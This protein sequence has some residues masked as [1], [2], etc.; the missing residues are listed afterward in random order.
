MFFRLPHAQW[1]AQKGSGNK[2]ALQA[3]VNAGNIPGLIAYLGNQPAGWCAVG[4]RE[5]YPRLKGSRNFKPVDE[6]TA[7]SI[8]CF[9]VARSF[10]R[11]GVSLALLQ[12]ACRFAARQGAKFVEGYPSEPKAGYPDVFYYRGL[13]SMF[14]KA[15]FKEVAR[16]SATSPMMRRAL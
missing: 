6:Q 8:T 5:C 15:G 3:L 2:R 13:P 16:R 11:M 1:I 14:R 10:R 7:W 12:E 4:P 9:F